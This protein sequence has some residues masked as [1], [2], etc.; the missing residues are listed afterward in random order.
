[1]MHIAVK[2]VQTRG[3]SMIVGLCKQNKNANQNY[4]LSIVWWCV[5]IKY[6]KWNDNLMFDIAWLDEINYESTIREIW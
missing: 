6:R 5:Q 3:M 2:F 4:S 1:M